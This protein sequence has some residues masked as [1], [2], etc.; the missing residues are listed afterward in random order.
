MLD[1]TVLDLDTCVDLVVAASRART[2]KAGIG[3]TDPEP[4]PPS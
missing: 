2:R 3:R 4:G 1:S